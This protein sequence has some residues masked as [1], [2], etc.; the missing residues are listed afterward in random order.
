MRTLNE[1]QKVNFEL[2]RDNRSGK[3]SADQ[4]SVCNLHKVRLSCR[5]ASYG[6]KGSEA[7]TP[8]LTTRV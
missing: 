1:N 4:L 2:V 5:V 6:G 3:L 7:R 8:L